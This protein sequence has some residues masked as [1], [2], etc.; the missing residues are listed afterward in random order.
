[1]DLL[2]KTHWLQGKRGGVLVFLLISAL[3]VGGLGWATA[4]ALRLENEQ[5]EARAERDVG[6]TLR[7]ALWRLDA[8]VDSAIAREDS[9]AYNHYSAV[10]APPQLLGRDGQPLAPGS[11]IELSPLINAEMPD[12][13]RLHFQAAEGFG[14]SSPQVP[15][16]KLRKLLEDKRVN[17]PIDPALV[18]ERE[19]LLADLVRRGP[20]P[21]V[22]VVETRRH[23]DRPAVKDTALVLRNAPNENQDQGTQKLSGQEGVNAR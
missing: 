12:W 20:S 1:M 10:S 7:L 3:V 21:G 23:E 22:L 17:V 5:R 8:R 2:R 19:N 15:S 18:A 16:E 9:R 11:V 13:M 14:W 6:A 4:A